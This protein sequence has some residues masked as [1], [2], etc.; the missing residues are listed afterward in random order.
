M[1]WYG[2]SK[3]TSFILQ[4]A[5]VVHVSLWNT[6]NTKYWIVAVHPLISC[7]TQCRSASLFRFELR[8]FLYFANISLSRWTSSC[9]QVTGFRTKCQVLSLAETDEHCLHPM[10]Q[11]Q[12][13]RQTHTKTTKGKDKHQDNYINTHRKLES[14]GHQAPPVCGRD[15][16]AVPAPCW[17]HAEYSKSQLTRHLGNFRK[18]QFFCFY[19]FSFWWVR[20]KFRYCL[21]WLK[22]SLMVGHVE[23]LAENSL[24]PG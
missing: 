2:R 5:H 9:I 3:N 21:C 13:Q 14:V 8:S 10:R 4:S 17:S 18:S 1:I 16:W 6:W 7:V 22:V 19:K 12:R 23:Q 24:S 20:S 11:S 15:R